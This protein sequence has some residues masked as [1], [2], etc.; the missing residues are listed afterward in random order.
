MFNYFFAFSVR[1]APFSRILKM[2]KSG[3]TSPKLFES[4]LFLSKKHSIIL[5]ECQFRKKSKIAATKIYARL[6]KLKLFEKCELLKNKLLYSDLKIWLK[7]IYRSHA[8]L[9]QRLGTV[10]SHLTVHP[11]LGSHIPVLNFLPVRWDFNQ[12]SACHFCCTLLP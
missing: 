11:L 3:I 9:F 12:R 10:D 4:I 8:A 1:A 7:F 6:C 5:G 2:R